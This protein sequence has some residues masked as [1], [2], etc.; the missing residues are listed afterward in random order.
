MIRRSADDEAMSIPA[1]AVPLR[2]RFRTADE[3]CEDGPVRPGR[4]PALEV[5]LL[6]CLEVLSG[7]EPIALPAS[8]KTRALLAYLI[9]TGRPHTREHLCEVFFEDPDNP[10]G[11][12][13]WSLSK[14]RALAGGSIA[15]V[16][17][18]NL[19]SVPSDGLA[20]DLARV[21]DACSAG[22]ETLETSLLEEL[23]SLFHGELLDG[24]DL[25][26]CHRFHQWCLGERE[27]ARALRASILRVLVARSDRPPETA[28]RYARSWLEIEP[29]S[30]AAHI[31]V[32]HRL[33]GLG[34]R[35]DALD[36][37]DECREILERELGVRPSRELEIARLG[38]SD[39]PA[40]PQEA[41]PEPA[42][43]RSAAAVPPFVGR[44][45]EL[46][47]IER[48]VDDPRLALPR[49]VLLVSGE[50][51]IG[52][53]RLLDQIEKRISA[54]GGRTLR[55]RAFE[56]ETIRPFGIWIDALP[57]DFAELGASSSLDKDRER[58]FAA[59][60]G[61]LGELSADRAL[62]VI[63]DDMQWIDEDSASLLN[64][65]LRRFAEPS[66]V[67]FALGARP[68][69]LADNAPALKVIRALRREGR[70]EELALGPFSES[71]TASLVRSIDPRVDAASVLRGSGGNP[72]FA[73]EMARSG[74]RSSDELGSETLAGLIGDR[75]DRLDRDTREL[76]P[77]IAAIG[78][79]FDG[80]LIGRISGLEVGALMRALED[81]ERHGILRVDPRGTY[82][83]AHDLIRETAYRGMSQPRRRLVHVHIARV[84]QGPPDP[85]AVLA[86]DIAHHASLGGDLPL[87]V[88]SCLRAGRRCL[89]LFANASAIELAERGLRMIDSIE[90]TERP[91]LEIALLEIQ[92]EAAGGARRNLLATESRLVDAIARAHASSDRAAET[93]GYQ[94]LS[95]LFEDS[96]D[97]QRARQASLF[98]LDAGRA[99]DGKTS[100]RQLANTS[101]C[102]LQLERDIGRARALAKE[103]L[104]RAS[105]DETE[106]LLWALALIR[107]FDGE[108]DAALALLERTAALLDL[109]R[110]RWRAVR[111]QTHLVMIAIERGRP[112]AATRAD[113][114]LELARKLGDDFD[115]QLAEGL[116][117]IAHST[118]DA[119]RSL[120]RL[121]RVIAKL[122]TLESK[123]AV[124]YLQ[125]WAAKLEL[126]SGRPESA[127]VRSREA[128]VSAECIERRSE[129]L[130]S[131]ACLA[132]IDL[133][134]GN[135]EDADRAF[136]EMI[137]A[138]GAPDTANARARRAIEEV[139]AL[140]SRP[141]ESSMPVPTAAPTPSEKADQ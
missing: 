140:L 43:A 57:V 59:A 7:G 136:E 113:D 47:A 114:L 44:R 112:E 14:I 86:S 139:G 99:A 91:G 66:R 12:L 87:A 30:E 54:V 29:T 130:L 77:W 89:R 6:G 37:Y 85:D 104:Q 71:E 28:L 21:R 80:E 64:Y 55:S 13:R 73:L 135:L 25:S 19:V 58:L 39:A 67:L 56:A 108:D 23:A 133:L 88:R 125:N 94:L 126:R 24:L 121:D 131:R 31:A 98:A 101:R 122:R 78:R 129:A 5:R 16:T 84:L 90:G 62:L 45:A 105:G 35:R 3:L 4:A 49:P 17:E 63:A 65:L 34:R 120:E 50:P 76:I 92:V 137:S 32:I 119:E 93:C 38:L 46:D 68:G 116:A 36:A 96:G 103:A 10:R 51:G 11:E 20:V 8:K 48:L 106:E 102:L 61:L 110:D 79:G 117:A 15:I 115:F 60:A 111:C 33:R 69:E 118:A 138:S 109:S 74:P 123:A 132:Q 70:I 100:A 52:K 124:A 22:V 107:H 128:L 82:D 40:E 1:H 26:S 9:S 27:A 127:A 18:Q 41:A 97:V 83:F 42:A 2:F 53:S 95:H 134:R 75:L 81:L 72:L 141:R